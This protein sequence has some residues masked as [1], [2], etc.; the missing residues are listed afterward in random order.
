VVRIWNDCSGQSGDDGVVVGHLAGEDLI[1]SSDD[2]EYMRD[3]F[4]NAPGQSVAVRATVVSAIG[5]VAILA[6]RLHLP[7]LG[8]SSS[9]L[10]SGTNGW[11]LAIPGLQFRGWTGLGGR[12][13]AQP[14]VLGARVPDDQLG[15]SDLESAASFTGAGYPAISSNPNFGG[16]DGAP[17]VR[18][19]DGHAQIVALAMGSPQKGMA[20]QASVI[21][22]A[23]AEVDLHRPQTGGC[24]Y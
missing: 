15:Y 24:G 20:E 22:Q 5:G 2:T 10:V 6:A 3:M 14:V 19:R 4:V 16:Y 9:A 8:F 1:A 23:L 21:G 11:L 12:P 13:V 7:A 18:V 17:I